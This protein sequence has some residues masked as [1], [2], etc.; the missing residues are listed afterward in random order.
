MS[1]AAA[2]ASEQDE[3]DLAKARKNPEE[4]DRKKPWYACVGPGLVT[5]AA[6]D[7]PSGVGT[8][9]ANGAQFGYGFLW[10]VPVCIPLMISVQ[11]MCGRLAAVTGK[12]LAA[13]LKGRFHPG[14]VYGSLAFLF[15]ANVFNVYA[16]LNIMAATLNMLCGV[17]VWAA[18]LGFGLLIVALQV[19]IPYR[20][21]AR[22]LKWL[23]LALLGY[24]AVAFF[25][26]AKV[27][28]AASLHGISVPSMKPDRDSVLALVAFL[29]TTISPYLFFWQAGETVEEGIK[30][31]KADEP[32]ER[33]EPASRSEIRQV[34]TDTVIGMVTSQAVA[35]FIIVAAAASL[36]ALGK[37][38]IDSAQ[39]AAKALAPL[40]PSAV[41]IFSLCIIAT[42]L[43]AIPTLAGS[44][45]YGLAE[46]CGWRYGL[47][48]R[49]ARAKPFYLTVAAVVVAG[50]VLNFFG[51]LSP[52]RALVLSS[53]LNGAVA[54]PLVVLL[55]ILCSDKTLLGDKV[56]G[57]WSKIF[58]WLTAALMG[59]GAIA[60][61]YF[62]VN[63]GI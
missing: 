49:F 56:N 12:G 40:G 61:L 57:V 39:D 31:R 23:C 48:R 60:L 36:H 18:N 29:G 42:G 2:S 17:P 58:G 51:A 4:C 6:D 5:G 14:I 53:A 59:V 8:Y 52:V 25:P 45:A 46:T 41:W 20:S 3:K 38:Q 34:K 54:P 15:L 16:D 43:L 10:L 19:L 32:G 13:C 28:W 1:E 24:V 62:A 9:S 30:E 21:Y 63:G 33:K 44:A 22:V 35:F 7:D 50:C 55:L 26:G 47:Y 37:T 27:D 11:E